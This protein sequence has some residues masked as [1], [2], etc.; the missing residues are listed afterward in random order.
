M[1]SELSKGLARALQIM[2]N[3]VSILS[4]L[5]K[6]KELNECIL[7]MM[8][9]QTKTSIKNSISFLKMNNSR[10]EKIISKIEYTYKE[11]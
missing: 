9:R 8:K 3:Q 7:D 5:H 6:A 11:K 10:I 2:Q 4:D 1:E